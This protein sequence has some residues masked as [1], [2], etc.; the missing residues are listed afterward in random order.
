MK[1]NSFLLSC[2]C[3]CGKMEVY[4]GKEGEFIN[5]VYYA[6]IF[7]DQY[8]NIFEIIKERI[9]FVF[10]ILSGKHYNLYDIVVFEDQYDE[11]IKF[12]LKGKNN[13]R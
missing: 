3:G 12:L 13:E 11:F 1:E 4:H 6:G 5:I 7:N 8:S 2:E 10:R 9:K